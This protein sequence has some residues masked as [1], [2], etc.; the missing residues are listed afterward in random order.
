M[1]DKTT[2]TSVQIEVAIP[3]DYCPRTKKRFCHPIITSDNY[4]YELIELCNHVTDGQLFSPMSGERIS[5]IQYDFDLKKLLE[6]TNAEQI[7]INNQYPDYEKE[8]FL[9]QLTQ[10]VLS[11]YLP[12]KQSIYKSSMVALSALI[13][14]CYLSGKEEIS[15]SLLLSTLLFSGLGDFGTRICSSHRYGLFGGLKR[16]IAA[17]PEIWDALDC[18]DPDDLHL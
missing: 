4:T 15:S 12:W 11:P 16:A 14:V 2:D 7:D 8:V 9:K 17:A 18:I 5:Y 3:F 13:T 1:Q 6:E 10:I